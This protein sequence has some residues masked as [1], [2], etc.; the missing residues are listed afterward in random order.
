MP[1]ARVASGINNIYTLIIEEGD[2]RRELSCRIKGKKLAQDMGRYNPI[3]VGDLVE[4]EEDPQHHG[5]G[6][7]TSREERRNVFARLNRKRGTMQTIVANMDLM[8]CL[9]SPESPPFRPR[10]IDRVL[11]AAAIGDMPVMVVVNK[12]D[13]E[14]DTAMQERL[15]AYREI[16]VEVHFCSAET[17]EGVDDLISRISGRDTAF[18]GQS[19]VG[20]STLLNR[21]VPGAELATGDITRKYNRGSHTTCFAKMIFPPFKGFMVDTPGIREI[22]IDGILPLDLDHYFPE[23]EAYLGKCNFSP[24][25]HDH[26]PGCAVREGLDAGTIHPDRYD[27]YLR[28]LEQLK[29]TEA[30]RNR[31]SRSRAK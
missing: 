16:G 31:G 24:C 22:D 26:E 13:Q 17:G 25:Y 9:T 27:S 21:I 3:A 14:I 19:G 23:F 15:E 20:K 7:I 1:I 18:V 8:V 4:Y 10:F 28:I 2:T 6:L 12:M 30:A 11:V 29:E 5:S